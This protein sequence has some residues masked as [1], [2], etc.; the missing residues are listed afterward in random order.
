MPPPRRSSRA[1]TAAGT[2]AAADLG[3][4]WPRVRSGRHRYGGVVLRPRHETIELA[5]GND[6]TARVFGDLGGPTVAAF[7]PG[8]FTQGDPSWCD[9]F[10]GAHVDR[11]LTFVSL[12]YRLAGGDVTVL[13]QTADAVAGLAWLAERSSRLVAGGHSAGGWLALMAATRTD[14]ASGIVVLAPVPRLS[15]RLGPIVP[16]DATEAQLDPVSAGAVSCSLAVVHGSDDQIVPVDGSRELVDRW[17]GAGA[18]ATFEM[19][20]GADHFFN[21]PR[22]ADAAHDLLAAAAARL[23]GS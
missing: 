2:T 17:R 7:H 4:A 9:R 19:V 6:A 22:H 1:T 12:P 20:D 23:L 18:D 16:T 15:A 10:A 3:S 13:D 21:Q 5:D 14:I 11:G 8:G